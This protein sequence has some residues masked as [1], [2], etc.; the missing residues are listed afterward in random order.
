MSTYNMF[1]WRNKK[2]SKVLLMSTQNMFLWGNKKTIYL[3]TSFICGVKAVC[4]YEWVA[5]S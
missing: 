2:N 3:D 1:L 4:I 5:S